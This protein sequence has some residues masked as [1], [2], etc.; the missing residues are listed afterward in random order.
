[1]KLSGGQR[2]RLAI[3]RVFLTRANIWI[4]DEATSSLDHQSE[5]MIHDVIRNATGD[6]TIIL[7]AHRLSSL[8]L[9]D[10][11]IVLKDGRI[12]AN[13][14]HTELLD[15]NEAYDELFKEQYA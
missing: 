10:R 13:G 14:H 12:A 6:K 9:A 3:A 4:L 2:Q 5:R 15:R 11:V 8:L 7:I 1:M